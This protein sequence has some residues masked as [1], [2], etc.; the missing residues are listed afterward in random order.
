MNMLM[1]VTIFYNS[2][3]GLV[4][5]LFHSEVP[6]SGLTFL[7]FAATLG[8]ADLRTDCVLEPSS[9]EL[10]SKFERR[11]FAKY[12]FFASRLTGSMG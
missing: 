10:A 7:V 11:T 3:N 6:E 1:R 8:D 2:P 5:G 9:F 12:A 4:W